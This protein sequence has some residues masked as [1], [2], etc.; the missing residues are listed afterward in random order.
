[1]YVPH[2]LSSREDDEEVGGHGDDNLLGRAQRRDTRLPVEQVRRQLKRLGDH[3][4]ERVVDRHGR[5][6]GGVRVGGGGEGKGRRGE[7]ATRKEEGLA[8]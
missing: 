4:R 6:G 8:R 5:T 1:M 7:R 2:E 3:L